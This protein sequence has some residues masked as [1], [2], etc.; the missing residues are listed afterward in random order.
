MFTTLF[1][2]NLV[3]MLWPRMCESIFSECYVLL[4]TPTGP[5]VCA[6]RAGCVA[7]FQFVTG[8]CSASPGP[9]FAVMAEPCSPCCAWKDSLCFLASITLH[10]CHSSVFL[11]SVFLLLLIQPRLFTSV[12][13]GSCSASTEAC[14]AQCAPA[15][16]HR[17][18]PWGRCSSTLSSLATWASVEPLSPAKRSV[19][20]LALLPLSCFVC[21]VLCF[22][23]GHDQH[24]PLMRAQLKVSSS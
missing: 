5:S 18:P 7:I 6:H 19:P 13:S 17:G 23:S 10:Q 3:R 8:S 14:W 20:L 12:H 4:A 9:F 16:G 15:W 11:F 21:Q 22:G 1:I 2:E 24:L